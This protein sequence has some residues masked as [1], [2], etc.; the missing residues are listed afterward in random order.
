MNLFKKSA[1]KS[2]EAVLG[3]LG[4]NREAIQ[5]GFGGRKGPAAAAKALKSEPGAIVQVKVYLIGEQP[6]LV[7]FGG[8][9]ECRP[10]SLPRV[11]NLEGP[12]K[13]CDR[14]E[15]LAA[16]GFEPGAVPP[17]PRAL[18]LNLPVAIDA[19]LKRFATLYAP[20]GH[21]HWVFAVSPDELKRLTQG[22]VSYNIT[23][24]PDWQ[25]QIDRAGWRSL[26]T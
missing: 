12:V 21:A 1:V 9:A 23:A 17:L 4:L 5:L 25:G 22:V 18:T 13:A 11:F 26:Q 20:A 2:V 19:G 3:E 8:G 6:V 15:T 14:E 24:K 16:T 7:L 10:E